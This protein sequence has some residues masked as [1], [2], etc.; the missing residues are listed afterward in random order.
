MPGRRRP[1]DEKT[2]ASG[3]SYAARE[4]SPRETVP[5][6]R[7]V[8]SFRVEKEGKRAATLGWVGC[9][10]AQKFGPVEIGTGETAQGKR[11][12]PPGE[13]GCQSSPRW[14]IQ[15]SVLRCRYRRASWLITASRRRHNHTVSRPW[16][17]TLTRPM[18]RYQYYACL[19]PWP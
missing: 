17:N 13:T 1:R 2:C 19:G 8:D 4:R 6:S 7:V 11:G 9:Q 15:S 16:P 14:G 18:A 3:G 10:S 5:A 12:D